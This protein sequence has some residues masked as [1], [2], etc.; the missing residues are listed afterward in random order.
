MLNVTDIPAAEHPHSFP[1]L[2]IT[3]CCFSPA[4]SP[5][6]TYGICYLD[7]VTIDSA[8]LVA[9]VVQ[10]SGHRTLRVALVADHQDRNQLHELLH[11]KVVE[12]A[13]PH[14]WLQSTY[15]SVDLPPGT[16]PATLREALKAPA[17]AGALHWEIDS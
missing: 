17:Q 16:D 3:R 14:E 9:S 4:Q 11:G 6:F 5:F 15:L 7:V 8:H 2:T 13:L 10:K 1:E 12:A